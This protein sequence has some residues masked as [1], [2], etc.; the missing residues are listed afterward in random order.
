MSSGINRREFLY[1]ATL[2]AS[3]L[4]AARWAS[5]AQDPQSPSPPVPKPPPRQPLVRKGPPKKVLIL[6]AGL[7]GLGAGYELSRAGHEV[8]ILEA[9]TRPGGRVHTLREPFS[10]GLYVNTGASSLP[11]SHG[12][13]WSYMEELGLEADPWLEPRL[14]KMISFYHVGGQRVV[15]TKGV[16]LPFDTTP[17]ERKMGSMGMLVKY[18]LFAEEEIGDPLAPDWPSPAARKYDQMSLADLIRNSGAS[19]AALKLLG[20]RFYLDLPADGME[21]VSALWVLRDGILSP[22]NDTIHKIRGGMDRLPRA[23]ADRLSD[24]ILYGCPV[25]RIGHSPEG[26]EVA[27]EQGGLLQK[28]S[29]DYLLC[30][31]PFSVLRGLEVSPGFSPGKQQ[32]IREMPYCSVFRT[33]LQTRSRFWIDQGFSGFALT[34]LPIKFVFDSSS[35]PEGRRGLLETYSSGPASKVFEGVPSGERIEFALREMEKLHPAIRYQ[36]EGGAWKCWMED[37]WSRG[38][39]GYYKPGQMTTLYPHAARAEGR[40]YFAG[41][42]V[43]PWPH[44][45]QGG[46]YSGDRAAR[47]INDASGATPA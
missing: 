41:E 46:L 6:G 21:E 32:V 47:E 25:V 44:W 13:V 19:P 42:H 29:A 16:P 34:D 22:G 3:A 31:L 15:P 11:S 30:T 24:K 45:M 8:T 5:A 40:V 9:Q 4:T 23:L 26:V 43:S 14:S 36:F 18:Y 33:F 2:A 27:F 12:L 39:Y 28:M 20:L 35:N 38:A 10:D 17:E 37:P 7:A 1:G